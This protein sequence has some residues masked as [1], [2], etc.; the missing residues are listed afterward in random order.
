MTQ[1]KLIAIKRGKVEFFLK[2]YYHYIT[3]KPIERRLGLA[4]D[5]I[6]RHIKEGR[7]LPDNEIEKLDKAIMKMIDNYLG[8]KD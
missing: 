7:A 3:K 8:E 5:G 6:R 4:K 2:K 1:K